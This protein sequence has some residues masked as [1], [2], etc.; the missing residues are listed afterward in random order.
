MIRLI[1]TLLCATAVASNAAAE[2]L[3]LLIGVGQYESETMRPLPYSIADITAMEKVLSERGYQTE[4]L[5]LDPSDPTTYRRV[6][7]KE[8]VESRI[9]EFLHLAGRGDSLVLAFAGHGVNIDHEAYI[10]PYD[11]RLRPVKNLISVEA[12]SK[13]IAA[14]KATHVTFFCDACQEDISSDTSITRGAGATLESG[15]GDRQSF[16]QTLADSELGLKQQ[17]FAILQSCS[18]NEVAR[19]DE[20]LKHGVFFHYL[21]EGIKGQADEDFNGRLEHEELNS[22]VKKNVYRYVR[23]KFDGTQTVMMSNVGNSELP[24]MQFEGRPTWLPKGFVPAEGAR[25]V[26]PTVFGIADRLYDRVVASVPGRDDVVQFA[27]VPRLDVSDPAS[28]Y[29]SIDK[30]TAGQFAAYAQSVPEKMDSKAAA[31]RERLNADPSTPAFHVTGMEAMR[32]ARDVHG[33]LLP[34]PAQWDA[35]FGKRLDPA[36]YQAARY[37]P[38][39]PPTA[40]SGTWAVAVVAPSPVDRPENP[41]VSPFGIRDLGSNGMEFTRFDADWQRMIPHDAEPSSMQLRGRS[42]RDATGP[43][44]VDS[45]RGANMPD[46][47]WFGARGVNQSSDDI[48]FRVVL[49]RH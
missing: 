8:R 32:Y 43:L 37:E 47:I 11:A 20:D 27:L 31:R 16:I 22:Y 48:G 3:A 12:I 9:R 14:C 49:N 21:I 44:T 18:P 25:L 6:P 35:A 1:L 38:W 15:L 4:A 34:T 36:A 23:Q 33:G 30:I 24:L 28:F 7:N 10:C 5:Y 26:E 13:Q 45:W 40:D 39:Q 46:D 17:R 2:N 42:Y 41:D 19:E 29:M